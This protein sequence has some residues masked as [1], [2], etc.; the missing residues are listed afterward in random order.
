[1]RNLTIGKKQTLTVSVMVLVVVG[2]SYFS[3]RA[4]NSLESLYNTTVDRTFRRAALADQIN[5]YKSDVM[6]GQRG[7]VFYTLL[8]KT[9]DAEAARSQYHANV[10]LMA[11][12]IGEL[13]P[14]IATEEGKQ[15]TIK[16][17]SG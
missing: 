3:L 6:L 2:L 7:M 17:D 1:M 11:K 8:R 14:L 16:I 9:A 13:R 5:T 4:V 15:L 10:D 12:A